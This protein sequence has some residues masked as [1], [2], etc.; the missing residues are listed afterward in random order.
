[1]ACTSCRTNP[2]CCVSYSTP[3]YLN[4]A[5]C[6]ENHTQEVVVNQYQ[7]GVCPTNS[8]NVPQCGQSAVLDVA[9]VTGITI[10]ANIWHP[11]Y[12]YFEIISVNASQG[13]IQITNYCL[14]DNAAAGVQIPACTCFTITPPSCCTDA[15]NQDGVFVAYDFTAPADATC[16]DIILTSVEGLIAGNNVQIGTGLYLLSEIKA[17]NVITICNEGEGITPGTPVI[18]K[19]QFEFYQ[20]PVQLVVSNACSIASV[21]T[22]KVLACNGESSA[23]LVNGI[24]GDVLTL[25]NVDGTAH[26]ATPA[27]IPVYQSE[28]ETNTSAPVVPTTLDAGTPSFTSNLAGVTITNP[29]ATRP[30]NTIFTV[31]GSVLG[32]RIIPTVAD[33]LELSMSLQ[34]RYDGGGW[35]VMATVI[36]SW[37][38]VAVDPLPEQFQVTW[39]GVRAVAVSQADL[40]EA[41]LEIQSLTAAVTGATF[42]IA[43]LDLTISAYGST[44]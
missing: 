21:A 44:I 10:G 43:T 14:A 5:V 32:E 11:S 26:Y 22:G 7:F 4:S 13:T 34:V 16:L 37:E 15:N 29:N 20:Y 6:T 36:H 31:T 38:F 39:T 24:V 9:G 19:N 25:T 1:M 12:G 40:I 27:A 18:A 42:D 2:C 17:N 23:T 28:L 41:R 30:M 33:W 35:N 3:Y 8:W